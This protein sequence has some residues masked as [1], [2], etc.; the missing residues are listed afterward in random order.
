MKY[1]LKTGVE[2]DRFVYLGA[3]V[4]KEGGS[5]LDIHNRAVKA[6]GVFLRLNKIW[7]STSISR[8][9][10]VRLCKTLVKPVSTYRCETWKMNKSDEDKIDVVQSGCLRQIFK[11]SWQDRITNKDVL[12]MAET[13]NP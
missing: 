4:S 2:L 9:T 3:T 6:R 10:K 13:E 8:R 12:Q 11:I 1:T 7:S 5:T